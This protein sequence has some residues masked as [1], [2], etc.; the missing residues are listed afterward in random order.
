MQQGRLASSGPKRCPD[1]S[2]MF[3]EHGCMERGRRSIAVFTLI[4]T[5]YQV[6]RRRRATSGYTLTKGGRDSESEIT[7]VGRGISVIGW[8][9]QINVREAGAMKAVSMLIQ[10][11]NPQRHKTRVQLFVE[12]AP[13]RTCDALLDNDRPQWLQAQHVSYPVRPQYLPGYHRWG[14][15]HHAASH[16]FVLIQI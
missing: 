1:Y 9:V 16:P 4:H 7:A 2:T 12:K 3:C 10:K 14:C 11:V 6:S 13:A 5:R 8:L 15:L